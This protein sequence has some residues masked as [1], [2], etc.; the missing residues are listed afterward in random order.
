MQKS[1][2]SKSSSTESIFPSPPNDALSHAARE[3]W[4]LSWASSGAP[5]IRASDPD[6]RWSRL[7]YP[8][9][10]RHSGLVDDDGRDKERRHHGPT[11]CN[12]KLKHSSSSTMFPPASTEA[13]G[14]S[15]TTLAEPT[16]S[17]TREL[18]FIFITCLAQLLSLSA[19]NQTVAPVMVLAD[20]FE[21]NDYGTLSWFS[22]SYSM[23]VGTFILPAGMFAHSCVLLR[24]IRG[25][26]LHILYP[27][28]RKRKARVQPIIFESKIH[29][30]LES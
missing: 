24:R 12:S 2:D 10:L 4:K 26:A 11:Q 3:Y 16:M 22:A 5:V 7:S 1:N 21:I 18:A 28:R 14:D 13:S 25:P 9:S 8:Y 17:R 30:E 15:D 20:Y 6:L 23:S 29:Q 19:M 27:R